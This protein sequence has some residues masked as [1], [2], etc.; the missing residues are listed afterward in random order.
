MSEHKNIL[1]AYKEMWENGVKYA[2]SI[3]EN[4][5]RGIMKK[6]RKGRVAKGNAEVSHGNNVKSNAT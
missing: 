4:M 5:E 6:M 2:P 1:D 3:E